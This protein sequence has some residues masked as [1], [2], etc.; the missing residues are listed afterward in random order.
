MT[1]HDQLLKAVRERKGRGQKFGHGIWP[2]DRYVQTLAECV[3]VGICQTYFGGLKAQAF[4]QTIKEAAE[5]LTFAGEQLV[6]DE[7]LAT[8]E[9]EM[10]SI[11]GD[12]DLPAHSMLAFTHTL[13]TPREDRD[14]DILETSGAEV[15]SKM[16]LLWQHIHTLPIGKMLKV[17]EKTAERL[18]LASVLLDINELT[19]DAAKLIEAKALRFSHGFR[20]LD[21][22][23]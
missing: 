3:G 14:G 12:M 23:E 18:R 21:F 7:K 17:V 9:R 2:A 20:A 4:S 5:K 22:S 10:K 8:G 16:P 1:K 13:T 19:S 11:L 15:D 6:L